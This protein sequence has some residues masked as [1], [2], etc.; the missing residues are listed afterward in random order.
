MDNLDVLR[1]VIPV[2]SLNLIEQG[3]TLLKLL[4]QHHVMDRSRGLL[5]LVRELV[6]LTLNNLITLILT[7]CKGYLEVDLSLLQL[8]FI[9]V[10]RL[11]K[12]LEELDNVSCNV[13]HFVV[14]VFLVVDS[15][16]N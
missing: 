14:K 6:L 9:L 7:R 11:C 8:V 16:R 1:V 12:L 13:T 10:K 2:S 3:E 4:V 5:D 15:L